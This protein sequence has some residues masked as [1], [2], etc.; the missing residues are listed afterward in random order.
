[1]PAAFVA[2]RDLEAGH[3]RNLPQYWSPPPLLLV[4]GQQ[5]QGDF[6]PLLLE[7]GSQGDIPPRELSAWREALTEYSRQTKID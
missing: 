3:R 5:G 1:M 2:L 6:Q 7:V 4:V